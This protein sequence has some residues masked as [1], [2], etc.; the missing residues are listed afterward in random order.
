MPAS[1]PS[2]RTTVAILGDGG[3]ARSVASRLLADG[4]DVRL[5]GRRPH[6]ADASISDLRTPIETVDASDFA[7]VESF[8]ER[9]NEGDS[10]A[11]VVNC[12]G[13]LLLKPAHLTSAD[14]Y[15]QTITSNLTTAFATVRAAAR[16]LGR[17]GGS[18]VLVSSAAA[19][20]G[21]PNHEAIAAAKAGVAGLVRSA[22]AT[23]AARGLRFN[24]IAPGLLET[25]MTERI[26]GSEKALETSQA[27]HALGR[28]GTPDEA[29]SLI[30]W[31]LGPD[32]AWVTGQIWG[33]DGG[34]SSVKA[35]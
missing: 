7:A 26:T 32:S 3:L 31:L 35:R 28:I 19:S 22:A 9:S 34:L 10:L 14:D 18:V 33:I 24:A 29:A 16:V 25:P 1:P 23:Y 21:L 2:N 17:T 27:M 4:F 8:L 13:S 20:Y 11:G 30:A 12:A 6:P 15:A 5:S